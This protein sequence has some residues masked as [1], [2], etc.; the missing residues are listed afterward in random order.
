[1]KGFEFRRVETG[2]LIGAVKLAK[3]YMEGALRAY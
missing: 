1:M 3:M 2:S